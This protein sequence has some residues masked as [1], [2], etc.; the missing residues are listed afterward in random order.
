MASLTELFSALPWVPD[1]S[2]IYE[3]GVRN[4][5]LPGALA[6]SGRFDVSASRHF[7]EPFHAFQNDLV[8]EVNILAPPR[9]GKTLIADVCIPWALANDPGSV[10]W[11]FN[12]DDQAKEH[13][14][15]RL[16]PVLQS[17]PAIAG[18]LPQDRHKQRT[19]EVVFPSGHLLKVCGTSLSNLQAKGY[20]YVVMDE[21]WQ[22]KPGIEREASARTLDFKKIGSSKI[23]RI[24]QGGVDG[25]DWD[26]QFANG[27]VREWTVPCAGC[28]VFQPL[29]WSDTR[30]D[31]SRYGVVYESEKRDDGTYNIA[32]AVETARYVCK[33]C[34]HE[35]EN[36]ART[37]AAW[38]THGRYDNDGLHQNVSFHWNSIVDTDLGQLVNDWLLARHA[39]RNGAYE[40]LIKFFQ[41]QLATHKSERSI[42]DYAQPINRTEIGGEAVDGETVF[43]TVDVQ[44]DQLLYVTVRAWREN[45]FSRR[46]FRGK[47]YGFGELERVRNEYKVLPS[48]VIIDAGFTPYEVY[49]IAADHGYICTLGRDQMAFTHTLIDPKTKV[50]KHVQKP[51]SPRFWGNP[52]MGKQSVRE[53]RMAKAFYVAVPVMA[54]WLQRL[55]DLGRWTE[56]KLGKDD[57]QE[58]E[59][60]SQMSAEV[61]RKVRDRDGHAREK[62]VNPGQRDNHFC[63][64]ARL[65]VFAAMARGLIAVDGAITQT[66]TES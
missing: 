2:P 44:K 9:S 49:S 11:L 51:W 59:Y 38:N 53:P 57:E 61:K 34:G 33:H 26:Q 21:C 31:G 14:E 40:P 8:R 37:R 1:R 56:P 60:N 63:D 13:C 39:T 36:T 52:D 46:L 23:L 30:D 41:K 65:Q 10:L 66:A 47:V 18:M 58:R 64:C 5:T 7:I 42:L 15:T 19:Q 16:M 24:S 20:R 17:C 50:R 6:R 45:G 29:I 25:S 12:S 62:W 54:D 32:R 35:H 28:G 22:Y 55:I 3:W 48:C 27:S 43:M 4:V